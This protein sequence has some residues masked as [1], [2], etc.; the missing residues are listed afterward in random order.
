VQV[1]NNNKKLELEEAFS[2]KVV[3]LF[4]CTDLINLIILIY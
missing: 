1:V 3:N 2:F 4:M